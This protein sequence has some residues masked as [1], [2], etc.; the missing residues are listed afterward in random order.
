MKDFQQ[1]IGLNEEVESGHSVSKI[2]GKIVYKIVA[3]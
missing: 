3:R 2:R 1:I